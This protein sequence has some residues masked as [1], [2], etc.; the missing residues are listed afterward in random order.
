VLY[1]Q[2]TT[3]MMLTTVVRHSYPFAVILT[4]EAKDT[5]MIG[6]LSQ[7]RMMMDP[8]PSRIP[9]PNTELHPT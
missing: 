2:R 9:I 3:N 5:G 6:P 8:P 7:Q 1:S 4:T